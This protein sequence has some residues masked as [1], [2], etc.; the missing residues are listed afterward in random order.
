MKFRRVAV[1]MGGPSSEREVSLRSG[2]AIASALSCRGYEVIAIDVTRPALDFPLDVDAVFLALHGTFGED[3]EVQQL[4]R[5]RGLPYTG[6]G[7]EA[8]RLAFNKVETK[9][10]CEHAGI[11]TPAYEILEPDQARTLPLPVVV[12][13]IRE[14]S[15]VGIHRV[16]EEAAWEAALADACRYN[17][18][19]LVETFIPG[20]ELTVGIVGDETLPVIEIRA[21]D[22]YYDYA[23]KYTQG[24]TEYLVPA[25][26]SDEATRQCQAMA[27]RAFEAVGCCGLGRVDFRKDD[28]GPIYLLEINTIPGFTET[29]LLPKAARVAGME[30]PDL[31]ERILSMAQCL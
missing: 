29:S 4:L 26:L 31:C 20:R 22:G 11:S 12:K 28:Q 16:F 2:R 23:A 10:C 27:R 8:S 17:N 1:L 24:V 19:A 14:G 9:I 30:F 18:Q 3:G 25:P 13:P 5:E 7:P 6:S 15:S 21:P